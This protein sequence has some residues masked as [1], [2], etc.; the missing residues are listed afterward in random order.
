[1]RYN[2]GRLSSLLL[3]HSKNTHAAEPGKRCITRMPN[4]PRELT[5]GASKLGIDLQPSNVSSLLA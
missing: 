1:M 3:F 5:E 2:P 4:T